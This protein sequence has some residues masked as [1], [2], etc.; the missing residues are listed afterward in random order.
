[1]EE[2][3]SHSWI[4]IRFSIRKPLWHFVGAACPGS[5]VPLDNQLVFVFCGLWVYPFFKTFLSYELK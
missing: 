5:L 1:M 2:G 3:L 4:L